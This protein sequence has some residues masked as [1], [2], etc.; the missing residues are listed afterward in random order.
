MVVGDKYPSAEV[1]GLDLSPIQPIWVPSNVHFIVDDI[2][3]TWLAGD[4]FDFVHMRN[5]AP[6]LKSPVTVL[7]RALAFGPLRSS[8]ESKALRLFTDT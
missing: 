6:I 3:D 2:E 8:A 5:I 1:I 7:K 4:D